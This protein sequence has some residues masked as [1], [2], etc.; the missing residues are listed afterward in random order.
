MNENDAWKFYED[1]Y[2]TFKVER[3][4]KREELLHALRMLRKLL[5]D[6]KAGKELEPRRVER[7]LQYVSFLA[8]RAAHQEEREELGLGTWDEESFKF[9]ESKNPPAMTLDDFKNSKESFCPF[10]V[11]W[12]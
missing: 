10:P 9:V 5:Q 4:K 2:K 1:G 3:E 11:A 6:I 12:L 7:A 8:R